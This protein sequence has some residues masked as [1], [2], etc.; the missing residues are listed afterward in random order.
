MEHMDSD[1]Y[2]CLSAQMIVINNKAITLSLDDHTASKGRRLAAVVIGTLDR[3][4]WPS[5]RFS[6]HREVERI[7]NSEDR[8]GQGIPDTLWQS[9]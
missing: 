5:V 1:L 6:R 2:L 8:A 3:A 9:S 4:L 7:K